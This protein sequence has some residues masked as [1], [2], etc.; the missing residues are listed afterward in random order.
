MLCDGARLFDDLGAEL[1]QLEIIR[2]VGSAAI[3]HLKYRVVK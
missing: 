1:P 2:V 3:T